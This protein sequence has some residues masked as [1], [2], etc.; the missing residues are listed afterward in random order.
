MG[1]D[2]NLMSEVENAGLDQ[3]EVEELKKQLTQYSVGTHWERAGQNERL[4]MIIIMNSISLYLVS[5]LLSDSTATSLIAL[6]SH[7]TSIA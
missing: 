1:S 7:I 2:Q 6:T 4:L 3:S 5:F